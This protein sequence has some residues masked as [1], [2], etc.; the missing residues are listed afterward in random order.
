MAQ[1]L[2]LGHL[3]LKPPIIKY[4]SSWKKDN[5]IS[6]QITYHMTN[7]GFIYEY[8]TVLMLQQR[9]TTQKQSTC[10]KIKHNQ[11]FCFNTCRSQFANS[12][13]VLWYKSAASRQELQFPLKWKKLL[14]KVMK[15]SPENRA[16]APNGGSKYGKSLASCHKWLT[17]V[18]TM[19]L[20]LPQDFLLSAC[21]ITWFLFI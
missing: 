8:L 14:S 17:V 3:R 10:Y 7:Y 9:K 18:C 21:T 2:L 15:L 11:F 1:I 16:S 5:R 19:L 6:Y 4:L 20:Y 13:K 12:E